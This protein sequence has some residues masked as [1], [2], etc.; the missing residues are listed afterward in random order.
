MSV[1][2]HDMK[3]SGDGGAHQSEDQIDFKKVLAVG[4]GS[5]VLFAACTVWA[6]IILRNETSRLENERGLGAKGASI[7]KEEIG[8]VDQVHFDSDDRLPRWQKERSDHLGSYGWVDRARGIVHIPIENAM[9][10]VAAGRAPV[11]GK[12]SP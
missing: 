7:G 2:G 11:P 9:E 5:L 10:E 1:T 12:G 3:G 4:L 8:I 6:V